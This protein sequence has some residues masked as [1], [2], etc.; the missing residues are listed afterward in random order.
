MTRLARSGRGVPFSLSRRSIV[1]VTIKRLRSSARRVVLRLPAA[2]GRHILRLARRL[3]GGRR[4][5]PGRYR[6][7]LAATNTAR[8]TLRLS[9]P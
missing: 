4:L 9:G 6:V 8:L 5:R 2:E 7:T 3:P 1:K